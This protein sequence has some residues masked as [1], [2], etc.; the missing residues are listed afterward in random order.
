[1][2]GSVAEIE[3]AQRTLGKDIWSADIKATDEVLD[4]IFRQYFTQMKE[5]LLFGKA[6]YHRL[7]HFI[8]SGAVDREI[9]EKLDGI[10]AVA[11]RARPGTT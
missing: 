10:L 1:M 9:G 3:A 8:P 2:Q 6:D 7:V 4:P 5:P 11:R